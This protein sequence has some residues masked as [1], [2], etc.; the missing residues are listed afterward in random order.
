[1]LLDLKVTNFRSI[2]ETQ[3][4]SMVPSVGAGQIH[5]T[6]SFAYP[7]A[8]KVAAMYGPNGSGKSNL[9]QAI[10]YLTHLLWSNGRMSSG[11]A[12][13]H[14]PFSLDHRLS[15]EPSEIEVTFLRDN[16]VWRYGVKILP[17][18]VHSE[19]LFARGFEARS[20]ERRYFARDTEGSTIGPILLRFR[21]LL[22]EMTNDNQLYLAKLD[23]N[24]CDLIEGA[25]AWLVQYLRPVGEVS[26]FPLNVSARNCKSSTSREYIIDFLNST[27][28]LVADIDVT[29]E[30]RSEF[31][32][33]SNDE[34]QAF[35]KGSSRPV[36]HIEHD[37]M[38]RYDVKFLHRTRDGELTP[39]DL[40]EESS[41]TINLFALAGPILE[42]LEQGYT[43]VVDELN[44][45]FHPQALNHIIELFHS[46]EA[47]PNGAQLIFTSHDVAIMD[48]LERDE[49]WFAEKQT[50][51]ASV[52]F[53]AADFGTTRQG[54]A[55]RKQSFG[56][57]YLE[58]RY[59]ALPDVDV[60]TAIQSLLKHRASRNA[61]H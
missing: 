7:E 45:S 9:I 50:D 60:V 6:G 2:A 43:L 10:G 30:E 21:R 23:Q 40:E 32:K 49:I 38:Q 12:L 1:M 26:N 53:S 4:F 22:L 35:F 29:I 11:D 31:S 48:M 59:G 58:G 56:K 61:T 57:R 54:G 13:P 55:R 24:N 15:K 3:S 44:Q 42:T 18:K 5:R 33:M 14:H 46:N 8:M 17:S 34:V 37:A 47:N 27:D 19:W 41:G 36:V 28:V 25:W 20:Q 52:Y 51:G 16:K 39:I